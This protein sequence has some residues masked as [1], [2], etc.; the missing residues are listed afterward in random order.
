MLE[1]KHSLVRG[2]QLPQR[3]MVAFETPRDM[4]KELPAM[5]VAS[6]PIIDAMLNDECWRNAPMAVNFTDRNNDGKHARNQS[7]VKMVYTD[8][9]IYLAWFLYDD[10]PEEIYATVEK[11]QMRLW[12]D[13][14]ISFTIDPFHTHQFNDRSFFMVNAIGSK[15]VSNPRQY[16]YKSEIP[17]LW[18]VATN[19][20]EDGWIVEME[21]PWK[22]LNYPITPGPVVMGI[23]FDRWQERTREN[24]WWSPVGFME[25]NRPDGHWQDVLPP[26]KAE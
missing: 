1:N 13:D 26:I 3:Q 8:E 5:K 16:V 17:R 7:I 15:F 20:S 11:D 10:H 9:A 6:P 23:N 4:P 14:W 18:N 19:I 2:L 24:S 25:D 21:I 12:G 22:M